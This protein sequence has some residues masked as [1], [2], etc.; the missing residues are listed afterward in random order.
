MGYGSYVLTVTYWTIHFV[1]VLSPILV[2]TLVSGSGAAGGSRRHDPRTAHRR[3]N[4]GL[5]TYKPVGDDQEVYGEAWPLVDEWRAL[6][7]QGDAGAKL[8]RARTRERIMALEIAPIDE[9]GLTLPPATSPMH[10]SE[11]ETH[12]GWRRR[13][14]DDLRRERVKQEMLL[15]VRRVLTFGV[16][17]Q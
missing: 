1:I 11:R 8:D 16:W 2:A 6:E 4:P 12:V 3:E 9:C 17:R 7:L 13:E 15:R 14:H 5:V 10:P